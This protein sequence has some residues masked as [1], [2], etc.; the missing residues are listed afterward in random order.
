MQFHYLTLLLSFIQFI[1]SN[2]IEGFTRATS[3]IYDQV[4]LSF[5]SEVETTDKFVNKNKL[6]QVNL[7]TIINLSDIQRNNQVNTIGLPN[8]VVPSVFSLTKN[9][10]PLLVYVQIDKE[11]LLQQ[12]PLTSSFYFYNYTTSKWN[13]E[14]T[15]SLNSPV[16]RSGASITID[17]QQNIYIFGGFIVDPNSNSFL[18]TRQMYKFDIIKNQWLDLSIDAINKGILPSAFHS[19][20]LI[21]GDKIV[22]LGGASMRITQ[23][24]D[25]V[26]EISLQSTLKKDLSLI[27]I[28]DI[29]KN[30][31]I[32]R[33]STNFSIKPRIGHSA[34]FIKEINSIL[35]YGGTDQITGK[36]VIYDDIQLLNLNTYQWKMLPTMFFN[37]TLFNIGR[38]W[39]SSLLIDNKLLYLYGDKSIQED[40]T[41]IMILNIQN[42]TNNI[43]NWDKTIG[44]AQDYQQENF[45][46][47]F[48]KVKYPTE[49]VTLPPQGDELPSNNGLI[50]GITFG[51]VGGIFLTFLIFFLLW[52]YKMKKLNKINN[53]KLN[54]NSVNSF[55]SNAPLLTPIWS[56]FNN[57]NPFQLDRTNSKIWELDSHYADSI[58]DNKLTTMNSM[59]NTYFHSIMSSNKRINNNNNNNRD[60]DKDDTFNENDTLI[61]T[62]RWS[63]DIIRQSPKVLNELPPNQDQATTSFLSTSVTRFN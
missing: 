27:T 52:K 58:I 23:D 18:L 9:Y 40:W 36:G 54:R 48:M 28:Y 50:L 15:L 55:L 26:K 59:S 33:N 51:L 47:L 44:P 29:K 21:E 43:I 2:K 61:A 14:P 35:I 60:E 10:P 46:N 19:A 1:N 25:D 42:I 17:E 12:R 38:A 3:I 57:N 24:N 37:Q 39:H 13:I 7:S 56:N 34:T 22:Y 30:Q 41:D 16:K 20:T 53:N 6:L 45:N 63:A 32:I 11:T 31:W 62:R 4:L 5:L 49:F 8:C